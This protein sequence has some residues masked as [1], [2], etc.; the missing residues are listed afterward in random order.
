AGSQVLAAGSRDGT[1]RTHRPA[2]SQAVPAG[3]TAVQRALPA[4]RGRGSEELAARPPAGAGWAARFPFLPPAAARAGSGDR[5][6]LCGLRVP[7][8][9][10]GHGQRGSRAAGSR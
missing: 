3:L 2:L 4:V 8:L 9:H 1:G 10:L 5:G 7:A 6:W